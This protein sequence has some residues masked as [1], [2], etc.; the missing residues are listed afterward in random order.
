MRAAYIEKTGA[1]DV[2]QVGDLPKPAAGPGQVL[3]K[4]GAAALNPID[5]YLRSGLVSMPMAFPYVIGCDLAGTVEAVGSGA[6]QLRAGDRVWGSN[7]GL[8][9]R[10]GVAAEYAAVG[11]EW[12]YPTPAKLSD[13]EAASLALVGIT[14]HLGLF[15]HGRLTAGETVYVPGGSG[16]VGSMV[17]QMARAIGAHVA[18][19]AGSPERAELCKSLGADLALNYKTD[20]IPAKLREFVP[21]GVDVWYETQRDPNLEVSVPLLRKRGRMILMAGRAAKPILPLGSFYSRDCS[22]LGFGMFNAPADDQRR[23][24]QDIVR[25]VDAGLLKP[26]VGR[27]FPLA[28]A[29]V[30]ERYLEQNTLEKAGTLT[31]KVVISL[32]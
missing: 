23:C 22:L 12:L 5:L 18:T 1:P 24:A 6:T 19:S 11:E 30:A 7:Q 4:V 14:A 10:P 2:I 25:W 13:V 3:V 16:G 31:G 27:V 9:G 8:L 21:E 20:D 17:V 32:D 28:E 15:L 29:A 26:Q